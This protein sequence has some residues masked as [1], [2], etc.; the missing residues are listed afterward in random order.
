MAAV[1][2]ACGIER[3]AMM[4]A[5]RQYGRDVAVPIL[6]SFMHMPVCRGPAE[7]SPA[8]P[9]VVGDDSPRSS[10]NEIGTWSPPRALKLEHERRDIVSRDQTVARLR[11]RIEQAR[12]LAGCIA[13]ESDSRALHLLAD[14]YNDELLVALKLPPDK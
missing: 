14:G 7:I 3:P 10:F 11:M 12:R 1:G 6:Y 9:A 4:I 2:N 13:L 8:E 5:K